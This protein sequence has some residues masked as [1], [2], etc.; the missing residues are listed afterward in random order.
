MYREPQ[1]GIEPMTASVVQTAET[2]QVVGFHD[3]S[4]HERVAQGREI[5]PNPPRKVSRKCPGHMRTLK[6]IVI[7][8]SSRTLDSVQ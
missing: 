7:L 1:I 3:R 6:C 8:A 2:P 4:L 5:T